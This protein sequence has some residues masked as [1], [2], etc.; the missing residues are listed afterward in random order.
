[1]VK[2]KQGVPQ[3]SI[4]GPIFFLI[5]I[6]DLTKLASA[7]NKIFL[8]ADDTSIIETNPNLVNF[9]TQIDKIFGDI[10][11]WLKINQ[12]A[13]NYNKTHYIHFKMKNSRDYE[14]KLNY[15]GN[16]VNS[17]SNTTFL[18]LIINDYLS[19]KAHIDQMM[20]K[21]NTACFVIRTIQA[22]MSPETL[23][24]VYFAYIHSIMSYGIIFWGSQPYSEKIFKI[25]KRVIRIIT[26]SRP[27]DS[28]RELL[29]KLEILS[30]YSQ[31]IFSLSIF[32]IKNKHLFYT[33]N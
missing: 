29:K 8:Y 15:L 25:Q 7:A 23:K 16:C 1:M 27:R 14:L 33:N 9:E 21:M 5:Y 30:L 17:S 26:N 3:G 28:C 22:I 11:N 31:Y 4:L 6:N 13:L 32:V 19:W 12:L 2:I 10:N 18:G 24:T 20:S